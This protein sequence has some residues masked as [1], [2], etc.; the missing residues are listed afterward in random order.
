MKMEQWQFLNMVSPPTTEPE[1]LQNGNWLLPEYSCWNEG[2]CLIS[3]DAMGEEAQITAAFSGW[4]SEESGAAVGFYAGKGGFT[5]YLYLGVDDREV[6]LRVDS[7]AQHGA[8]FMDEG[9]PTWFTLASAPWIKKLPV[10]L[11]LRRAGG[12][13]T[14]TL[15]G[16]TVLEVEA[17]SLP[18]VVRGLLKALPW[19][20]RMLPCHAAL[21]EAH[22]DG[23]LPTATLSGRVLDDAG[24]PVPFAGVHLAFEEAYLCR[25]DQDG[26]F[27]F[28]GL[29]RGWHFVIAAKE[30]YAFT[31]AAIEMAGDA[32]VTLNLP[33]ETT[34]PRHEYN[35]PAFDRSQN[36]WLCLNGTW[37]FA[38]DKENRGVSEYWYERNMPPLEREIRV[39]FS[40]SSL[41]GFGEEALVDGDALLQHN[42]V[43]ANYHL[44]GEYGWYRRSF[45]VPESFGNRHSILCIGA[46]SN[47]TTVWLDGHYVDMREDE[48]ALLRFD[49]GVLEPGSEHLLVIR[50]QYPHHIP[51]HNMGKQ[52]FWFASAPGIW[53]SVWLEARED[54]YLAR[55]HLQPVIEFNG[56]TPCRAAFHAEFQA[57]GGEEVRLTLTSPS[58][59][60]LSPVVFTLSDG[61][62]RGMMEIDHPILWE[63][64]K[65]RL[66]TA[67]VELLL[68]G[69]VVD[70]VCTYAGLRR[71]ETDWLPGRTP[72]APQACQYLYLNRKP[73]YVAGILDQGYNPFGI[74]TYR[75]FE[76]EGSEGRR[77]SIAYDVDRTLAYG[78]NLSRM[79]IKENEPLWYYE[80]DR[81]GLPVWTEHPGNFYAMPDDPDWRIA[82]AREMTGMTERLFN[83]PS[84]IVFSSINESWG[85]MGG[86]CMSPWTDEQRIRFQREAALETRRRMPQVLVCDNSGFGKTEA[87]D[88]NDFHL[89]P[90]DRDKAGEQWSDLLAKCI[91]GSTYNCYHR[92]NGPHYVGEVTQRGAP[93]LIS[94]FLHT[95]GIDM[96]LRMYEKIAGYLRMNVASHEVENSGPLTAERFERDY[97]YLGHDLTLRGYDCVNRM[98]FLLLDIRRITRVKQGQALA[99]PLYTSHFDPT[100][101][102]NPILHWSLAGV[103]LAGQLRRDLD[104]GTRAIEF[105]P[106][107]VQRQPEL[108]WTVP[109]NLRGAY[110]TAW[111]TDG[112]VC[113]CENTAALVVDGAAD[114]EGIMLP[115]LSYLEKRCKGYSGEY[116][117]EGREVL[118]MNGQSAVTYALDLKDD[119]HAVA[120]V[121]ECAAHR[122]RNAVRVTDERMIPGEVKIQLDGHLLVILSPREDSTD[123]RALFSNAELGGEPYDYFRLGRLGYGDRFRIP[124]KDEAVKRGR[125]V[126]LIESSR[127]GLALFGQNMGRYGMGLGLFQ[128]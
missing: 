30:G 51:S 47:V 70:T 4:D 113:V 87:G 16:E 127:A 86:H 96:Q 122:T 56:E 59:E 116:T 119:L 57:E 93:I 72:P 92:D 118:W 110:V 38:F 94:E 95:S 80:C 66:Y 21:R 65:G 26:H 10:E 2:T 88:L 128:G 78:Y 54:C 79:H 50:A 75:S 77:G 3:R 19:H 5:E 115:V 60:T 99:I 67:S 29:P 25:C 31:S 8:A 11:S 46:S 102:K 55:A 34:P 28:S 125:H 45:K 64:R 12:R 9:Q 124:L 123:E 52:I 104:G 36:G 120:L 63:Y 117:R 6:F 82:Y 7:G 101:R 121:L 13:V 62:A 107:C 27:V 81:R 112:D 91:P 24:Q 32:E 85:I 90:H 109:D 41:M 17:P 48:Y 15:N 71:V 76:S 83:H 39:P 49:L 61:E 126:L 18:T 98:D 42:P 22:L 43:T 73:L 105:R 40:W 44:T 68:K 53:Q 106:Y 14:A 103:D 84:V 100:E 35:D 111:I 97:G 20:D 33:L 108:K 74:Y 114:C 1:R 23:M 58:G 69:R 89:Y 37:Q